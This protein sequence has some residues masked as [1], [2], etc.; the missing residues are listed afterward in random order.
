MEQ[1][2]RLQLD[3][4]RLADVPELF[5]FLGDAAAM[6]HT[7]RH[8][9]LRECRR[10]VAA[11]ERQRR[12]LGFAPWTIRRRDDSRIIGWGGLYEDPFDCGWGVEIGYFFAP[13]AWGKGYATELTRFCLDIAHRRFRLPAVAAFAHPGNAGSRRVLEKAGFVEERYVPEM[14]RNLYRR[15]LPASA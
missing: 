10:H 2:A 8:E 15:V 12:H 7:H 14:D 5:A 11:H 6:R 9:S 3:R 4:P 13:A 1:T